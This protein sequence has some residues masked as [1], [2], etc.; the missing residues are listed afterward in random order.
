MKDNVVQVILI[1]ISIVTMNLR[2][3]A[4]DNEAGF[5]AFCTK[6]GYQKCF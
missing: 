3:L 2:F 5:D 1:H 6:T 4:S